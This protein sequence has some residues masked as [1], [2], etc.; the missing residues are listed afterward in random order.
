MPAR[1]G[2]MKE[3]NKDRKNVIAAICSHL[4]TLDLAELLMVLRYIHRLK[5]F[6]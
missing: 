2:S 1:R 3:I 6:R 4:K 5:E